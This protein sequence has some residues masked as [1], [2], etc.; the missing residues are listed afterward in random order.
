MNTLA[1]ILLALG[2]LLSIGTNGLLFLIFTAFFAIYTYIAS[3]FFRVLGWIASST[4]S[5]LNLLTAFSVL[6]F[7]GIMLTGGLG[8]LTTL[9]ISWS[10]YT[11]V[12][13]LTYFRLRSY[14]KL[15]LVAMISLISVAIAMYIV[16]SQNVGQYRDYDEAL[17]SFM[18]IFI[19]NMVSAFFAFLATILAKKP[20]EPVEE[21]P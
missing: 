2:F 7:G 18:I 13:A 6:I 8:E 17:P 20:V 11:V 14:S 15:Y 16:F 9:I 19:I 10:I 1:K 5:K 12:E 3:I 4:I 21:S